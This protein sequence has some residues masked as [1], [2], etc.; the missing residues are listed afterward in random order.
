MAQHELSMILDKYEKT[1]ID[2]YGVLSRIILFCSENFFPLIKQ[3]ETENKRV[4]LK[5]DS[6]NKAATDDIHTDGTIYL[7]DLEIR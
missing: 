4:Y 1:D 5:N 3:A 7:E 2:Y 6:Q